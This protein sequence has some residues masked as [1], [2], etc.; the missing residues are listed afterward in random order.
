MNTEQK[1]R[2]YQKRRQF[3]YSVLGTSCVWCSS[4]ED[5]VVDHIHRHQKGFHIRRM[6]SVSLR[7]FEEELPRL[8]ILCQKCHAQKCNRERHHPD[9]PIE[10]DFSFLLKREVPVFLMERLE[11]AHLQGIQE[12]EDTF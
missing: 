2:L 9:D 8:Q 10:M 12:E 11:Q 5:L 4:K 3:L 1:R 7:R 6:A